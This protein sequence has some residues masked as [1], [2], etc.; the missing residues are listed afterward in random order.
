MAQAL[1]CKNCKAKK[2]TPHSSTCSYR[3][4]FYSSYP[5]TAIYTWTSDTGSGSSGGGCD[6]SSSSSSSSS[7]GGGGGCE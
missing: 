4:G 6:T 1:R 5:D 3:N 2:G 7:D